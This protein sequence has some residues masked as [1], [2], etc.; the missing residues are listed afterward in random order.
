[1]ARYSLNKELGVMFYSDPFH[2]S[3]GGYKMCIR[4][5]PNGYGYGKFTYV[6]VF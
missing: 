6:S 2:T 4:V 1:M 5:H 3:P